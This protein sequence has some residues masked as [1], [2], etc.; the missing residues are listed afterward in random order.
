M[1]TE[2]GCIPV[3]WDGDQLGDACVEKGQNPQLHL[4][5]GRGRKRRGEEGMRMQSGGVMSTVRCTEGMHIEYFVWEM[6]LE[7]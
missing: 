6:L 3:C 1:G 2:S 7:Q 5:F 4:R